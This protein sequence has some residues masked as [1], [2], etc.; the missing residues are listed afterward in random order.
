METLVVPRNVAFQM[1]QNPNLA[2]TY[3]RTFDDGSGFTSTGSI[4]LTPS[5]SSNAP[6]GIRRL[7]LS[8]EDRSRVKV[9]PSG[10]ELIA[11]AE[12]NFDGS[13]MG[14]FEWQVAEP[15][16]TRGALVFRRLQ[17]FR[18]NLAGRGRV[19]LRSPLLPT[20]NDGLY[21]VR[22]VATDPE[23]NFN[24]PEVKYFVVPRK[25][26][27]AGPAGQRIGLSAPN[28][29]ALLT[30]ETKFSWQETPG[31]AVYQLEVYPIRPV[32]PVSPGKV[33]SIGSELLIDPDELAARPITGIVLPADQSSTSLNLFSLARLDT[34]RTYLWR[35]KAIS[36]NGTVIGTSPLRRISM[37]E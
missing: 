1:A 34:G 26:A 30:R 15:S 4:R 36:G 31:A 12:L 7:D 19:T 10:D 2:V 21:V 27:T 33:Q 16:S 22:L 24:P 20:N 11:Q 5:T 35:I 14:Q 28:E 18:R 3:R 13:G 29:G 17:V 6:L 23:L 32:E 8:F 9:L 37:P 25:D